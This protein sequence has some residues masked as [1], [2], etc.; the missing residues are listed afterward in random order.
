MLKDYYKI[1][2]VDRKATF[3]EIKRA[4]R[5][6][7]S[8][9]H[10][11]RNATPEAADRMAEI[12]E[13]Y[14]VLR[15]PMKR[16]QYDRRLLSKKRDLREKERGSGKEFFAFSPAEVLNRFK[17]HVRLKA[18]TRLDMEDFDG[19]YEG[20]KFL[21]RYIVFLKV[22]NE[23]SGLIIRNEIRRI[24]R[25][26]KEKRFVISETHLILVTKVDA[27]W[28]MR[29]LVY[30]SDVEV[31]ISVFVYTSGKFYYGVNTETGGNEIMRW[32]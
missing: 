6:L 32:F 28:R 5:Q 14:S 22:T 12:N 10:P 11:D 4:Y 23:I 16:L 31:I 25:Y 21:K 19:V 9:Y 8:K 20:R 27:F 30:M 17:E 18:L 1:L 26:L 15:N 13:A 7:A 24:R 2:G 29:E 3:E